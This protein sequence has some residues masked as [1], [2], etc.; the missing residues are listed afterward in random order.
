MANNPDIHRPP[1]PS[2]ESELQPEDLQALAELGREIVVNHFSRLLDEETSQPHSAL[3]GWLAQL[4]LPAAPEYPQVPLSPTSEAGLAGSLEKLAKLALAAVTETET[5]MSADGP[6]DLPKTR[7]PRIASGPGTATETQSNDQSKL[8]V[9]YFRLPPSRTK[10]ILAMDLGLDG[11]QKHTPEAIG[12]TFG[13][14]P[15]RVTQIIDGTRNWQP[16][17]I[18]HNVRKHELYELYPYLPDCQAKTMAAMYL[19]MDGYEEHTRQEISRQLNLSLKSV[20]WHLRQARIAQP[21]GR[22]D[23]R[24]QMLRQLYP[25]LPAGQEKEMLAMHLGEDGY[26]EHTYEQIATLLGLHQTRPG[27]IIDDFV[28]GNQELINGLSSRARKQMLRQLYPSLPA[29]RNKQIAAMYIG[30]D[31]Y[32]EHTQLVIGKKIGIGGNQVGSIMKKLLLRQPGTV[33]TKETL[34]QELHQL[35]PFL[36]EGRDKEMAAMY[37]GVDGYERRTLREIGEAFGI[38]HPAVSQRLRKTVDDW[39][40]LEVRIQKLKRLYPPENSESPVNP[41]AIAGG[42]SQP[43]C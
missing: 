39:T 24:K 41:K 6:T 10:T 5:K 14:S 16:T 9:Y 37:A 28:G 23:A 21:L 36:P 30:E 13:L 43:Y 7:P 15:E 31:G 1:S 22:G 19:G 8:P 35:H 38:T 12:E 29:G 42:S 20:D 25:S 11:H 2:T 18:D 34:R 3:R 26:E 17:R 4:A 32:E 27:Q 33:S 40:G